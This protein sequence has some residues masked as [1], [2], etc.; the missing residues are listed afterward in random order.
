MSMKMSGENVLGAVEMPQKWLLWQKRFRA[1]PFMLEVKQ[2]DINGEDA[3]SIVIEGKTSGRKIV[4]VFSEKGFIMCGLLDIES[5][6][7]IGAA[8]VKI[9]GVSS[10]EEI[11]ASKTIAVT[12][13]AKAGGATLGMTGKETLGKLLKKP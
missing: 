4:G 13:K 7:K 3:T 8:A 5:A 6:E 11:L 2:I 9:S 10:I 1:R 12:S